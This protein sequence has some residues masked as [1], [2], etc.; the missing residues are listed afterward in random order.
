M[1]KLLLMAFLGLSTLTFSKDYSKYKSD[2]L[3]SPA[4]AKELIEKN[5][6]IVVVD[7]RQNAKFFTGNIKG[8]YNMWRPDMEAKDGRYGDIGGMRASR[9]ELEKEMNT[10]GVNS[11]TTL[12]LLGDNLDEY[13]LWWVMDLYGA[14]NMKIVDGGFNALKATG[15]KTGF[16]TEPAPKVGNF[17][18]PNT[19][20]SDTL[21]IFE[22]VKAK[23]NNKDVVILDTRSK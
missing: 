23:F 6:N 13:R 16:G 21:A 8:S 11:D 12:L 20:D 5:K 3:I 22:E 14:K 15:I 2:T 10:M 19:P 7:V 9:E 4:V 17:K 18:F 1:K